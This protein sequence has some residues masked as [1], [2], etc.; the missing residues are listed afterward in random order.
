MLNV[1]IIEEQGGKHH[2][3]TGNTPHTQQLKRRH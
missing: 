2:M 3:K 1:A